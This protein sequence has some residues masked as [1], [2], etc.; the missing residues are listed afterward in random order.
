M[1]CSCGSYT[2]T[3]SLVDGCY[4]ECGGCGRVEWLKKPISPQLFETWCKFRY[5]EPSPKLNTMERGRI[6]KAIKCLREI[7][8]TPEDLMN[9]I[10]EFQRRYSGAECTITG[11]AA[12]WGILGQA[13]PRA[14]RDLSDSDLLAL[15]K[16][17]NIPTLGRSRAQLLA[18]LA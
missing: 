18:A 16:S 2:E 14:N 4:E 13:A 15:C 11:V 9:R 7:G 8:A 17:R 12:N 5:G 3:H 10:H 6:N 1:L